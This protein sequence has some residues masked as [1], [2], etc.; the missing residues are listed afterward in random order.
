MFGLFQDTP[1]RGSIKLVQV[2][3][4]GLDLPPFNTQLLETMAG[5]RVESWAA[6]TTRLVRPAPRF[7]PRSAPSS[8]ACELS[9]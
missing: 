3:A 8:P 2:T 7:P 5:L 6:F 4:G 9:V 1:W